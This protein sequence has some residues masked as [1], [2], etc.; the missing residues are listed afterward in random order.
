MAAADMYY[1]I[2]FQGE[3]LW[4]RPMLLYQMVTLTDVQRAFLDL[5][6]CF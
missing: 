5:K 6:F 3:Y 2:N 4:L 1:N